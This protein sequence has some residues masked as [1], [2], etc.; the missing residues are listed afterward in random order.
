MFYAPHNSYLIFRGPEIKFLT[1]ESDFWSHV[2]PCHSVGVWFVLHAFGRR[3]SMLRGGLLKSSLFVGKTQNSPLGQ[4]HHHLNFL[5]SFT[6]S[7][8]FSDMLAHDKLTSSLWSRF[9]EA[10]SDKPDH[11]IPNTFQQNLDLEYKKKCKL[12]TQLIFAT[13]G[14]AFKCTFC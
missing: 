4:G 1:F 6:T 7:P 10:Q 5:R 14:I 3:V 13:I 2:G 9:C 12:Y 8:S 11:L